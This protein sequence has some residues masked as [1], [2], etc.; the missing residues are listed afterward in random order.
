MRVRLLGDQ[1]AAGA[2]VVDDLAVDVLHEAAPPARHPVVERAVGPDGVQHGEALRPTDGGVVLAEGRSEV[3]QTRAIVR[4]DEPRRHDPLPVALQR[5]DVEG[6][7]VA[8]ADELA[9]GPGLARCALRPPSSRGR[10]GHDQVTPA[11][12]CRQAD[13]ADV[14]ADGDGDV[15]EQGP[16]RRRPDQ[17]VDVPIDD[18]EA[19]EHRRIDDVVVRTRLAQL[20]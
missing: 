14:G 3:D 19:H 20:V 2:E 1:Q 7:P 12:G 17:E 10:L 18:G 16:W 4:G 6:A 9:P 5:K 15:G 13:V 11:I 8:P